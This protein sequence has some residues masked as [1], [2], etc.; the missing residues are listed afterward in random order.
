MARVARE[1]ELVQLCAGQAPF[2]L[3]E[4]SGLLCVG[5]SRGMI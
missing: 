3:Q 2:P 5:S 1:G 4:G